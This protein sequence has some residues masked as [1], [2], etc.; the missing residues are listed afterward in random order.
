M[1]LVI[2]KIY[3]YYGYVVLCPA[4]YTRM[5]V[6]TTLVPT[7]LQVLLDHVF[8]VD[9]LVCFVANGG[10]EFEESKVLLRLIFPSAADDNFLPFHP[11]LKN[12]AGFCGC[13]YTVFY[14]EDFLFVLVFYGIN[15]YVIKLYWLLFY[16]YL[17]ERCI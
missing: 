7:L 2:N 17:G 11:Y 16:L 13:I 8:V 1:G 9:A 10:L 12:E 3:G 15:E 14:R 6:G 4:V 5:Y